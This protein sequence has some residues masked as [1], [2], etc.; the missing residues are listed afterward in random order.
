MI[1][2]KAL[3]RLT[4]LPAYQ[5]KMFATRDAALR[6]PRVDVI[7]ICD[8]TSG[9]VHNAAFDPTLLIYDESYQNEQGNSAAFRG[10]VDTVLKMMHKHFQGARILEVGCGK[11]AFLTQL[12]ERGHQA[13]G[14]DPAY[15]GDADYI[16]KARFAPGICV[17]GDAIV[18]RHVLEH[19]ARPLDFLEQIRAANGGE[20]LIYIEVPCLDWILAR[21][22]C[23]D[24]FYEHV[25]YF[26]LSDFD[27]IFGRVLESGRVFGGQYLYVFADL[28]TLQNPPVPA[29]GPTIDVPDDLFS[30]ME[31]RLRMAS[32]NRKKVLWGAAAKGVM[33]AHYAQAQ[34]L[35]LEFAIDINPAKQSMYIAG[36]GLQV[37]PPDRALELLEDG[38]DVFV[39]NSNYLAEIAAAGGDR[40]NYIPVD[41]A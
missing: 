18:M 22:A 17:R 12:R 13:I 1:E 33:F 29:F 2:D 26:R 40:F 8:R 31:G 3:L 30:T 23:F 20:G 4:G 11:G 9:V 27:R 28:S 16:L 14:V 5:N 10:H 37:L 24:F 39:M 35:R 34:G 36:T 21:R 7:L 6:C 32:V 41:Q 19:I 15:E 38:D 25:N